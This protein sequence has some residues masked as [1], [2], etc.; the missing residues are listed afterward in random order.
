MNVTVEKTS[1]CRR[2]LNVDVPADQVREE[3]EGVVSAY[4]SSAKIPGFRPGN[5]PRELVRKR[6][7]KNITEDL[8]ERLLPQSYQK[9]IAK[10][11]LSVVS[12]IG[13]ENVEL[14]DDGDGPLRFQVTVDVEPEF[15]LPPYKGIS[16]KRNETDVR[17]EEVEQTVQ[18]LLEQHATYEDVSDRGVKKGDLV[19]VDYTGTVEGTP[20]E[21][22]DPEAKG[23]GEREDFWLKADDDAF[24]PGFADGLQG[25]EIG[26][27]CTIQ[28]VFPDDFPASGLA[29]KTAE[30]KVT[31][32]GIRESRLPEI[33]EEFLK[34]FEM[35]SEEEL[36]RRIRDDLQQ[37]NEREEDRRLRDVLIKDLLSKV[38]LAVPESE[39]QEEAR[40]II[41]NVVRQNANRG[42]GE[43]EIEKHK[44]QI[45]ESASQ[46]AEESIKARYLL[47]R[48][49]REEEVEVGP[50]DIDRQIAS[51][52]GGYGMEPQQLKQE[53]TSKGLLDNVKSDVKK[54]KTV[55]FLLEQADIKG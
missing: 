6:Y 20:V 7:R 30:Y 48:I 29:G 50:E 23:L 36:R 24:L 2:V 51:M 21:E 28:S 41:Y 12:I 10:E 26:S 37:R 22:V 13:V 16:L 18:H 54:N 43:E 32:K 45:F 19:Q 9:A 25:V 52:A 35:E 5:A 33:D 31:V 44:D 40:N 53:L 42:V 17:E 38:D 14:D 46:E 8:K 49:A 11:G 47:E 1:P 39:V 27:T 3:L 15:A 55:E 4:R 34:Q